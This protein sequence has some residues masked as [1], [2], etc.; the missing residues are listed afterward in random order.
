M[1]CCCCNYIAGPPC[2]LLRAELRISSGSGP[3]DVRF[4]S[5]YTFFSTLL[6][7]AC[8]LTSGVFDGSSNPFISWMNLFLTSWMSWW[9]DLILG[10]FD[11]LGEKCKTTT[12]QKLK[13]INLANYKLN[14]KI[15]IAL[16][17]AQPLSF[18]HNICF[19]PTTLSRISASP[20]V[21]RER[22]TWK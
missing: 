13:S 17:P 12:S 4:F 11:Q 21:H 15:D 10:R 7:L 8:T 16:I 6:Y 14:F 2:Y 9:C 20:W 1:L 3:I 22:H 5:F 19:K 18:I